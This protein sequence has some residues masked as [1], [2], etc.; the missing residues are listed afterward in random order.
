[1]SFEE[2]EDGEPLLCWLLCLELGTRR[3]WSSVMELGSGFG[4]RSTEDDEKE[5]E[6]DAKGFGMKGGEG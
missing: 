3:L 2:E 4:R 1:L 6:V 5:E